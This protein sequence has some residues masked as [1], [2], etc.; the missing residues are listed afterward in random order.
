MLA[1]R[2][3]VV[4]SGVGWVAARGLYLWVVYGEGRGLGQG[5]LWLRMG[6]EVLTIFR[7]FIT[8]MVGIATYPRKVASFSRC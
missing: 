6:M 8:R 3:V 2:G 5:S 1:V 7:I 4:V